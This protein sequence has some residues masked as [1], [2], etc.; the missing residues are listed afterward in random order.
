MSELSNQD[1]SK[2]NLPLDLQR[3]PK[4]GGSKKNYIKNEN[5]SQNTNPI[6]YP[7]EKNLTQK[8]ALSALKYSGKASIKAEIEGTARDLLEIGEKNNLGLQKNPSIDLDE[9]NDMPP[10]P[11]MP[12]C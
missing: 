10:P 1:D 4:F 12:C 11:P 3:L 8:L 2:N 7:S 6:D 5:Y 9:N